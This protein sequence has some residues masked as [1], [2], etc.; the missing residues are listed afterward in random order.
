MAKHLLKVISS[1]TFTIRTVGGGLWLQ[2][3]LYEFLILMCIIYVSLKAGKFD[4]IPRWIHFA[5]S[6]FLLLYFHLLYRASSV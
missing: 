2:Q 1:A 6:L 5:T 4:I 3:R